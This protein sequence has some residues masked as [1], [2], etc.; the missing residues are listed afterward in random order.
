MTTD[1]SNPNAPAGGE[2]GAGGDHDNRVIAALAMKGANPP[3]RIIVY[4]CYG[5]IALGLAVLAAPPYETIKQ[6]SALGL[7]VVAL[8]FVAIRVINRYQAL[9]Q[10]K[11]DPPPGPG[12]VVEPEP[13]PDPPSTWR[14]SNA[15]KKEIRGVLEEARQKALRVL[16]AKN[17]KLTDDHVRVNVFLREDGA[18]SQLDECTLKIEPGLHL[19]M[20]NQRELA[21]ALHPGQGATGRA[22]QNR[23]PQVAQRLPAK[24]GGGWESFYDISPEL[25]AIIDPD[26]K[27]VISMPLKGSKGEAI[28]V[29][30]VDGLVQQ[31]DVDALNACSYDLTTSA[32]IV[33]GLI[34]GS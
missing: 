5:I 19:K 4:T 27:W 1:N 8:L 10:Q 24:E 28:G 23:K 33:A 21:I 3:Q 32:I 14:L 6:L 25:A 22:F 26:L 7:L 9:A 13:I 16:Q 11:P 15:D 18:R 34:M 17:G 30:S 20:N 31:F 29:M 2:S 12:P